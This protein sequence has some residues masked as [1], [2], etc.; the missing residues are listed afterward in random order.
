MLSISS[1]TFDKTGQVIC[2]EK[3]KPGR[4]GK[5]NLAENIYYLKAQYTTDEEAVQCA[6]ERLSCFVLITNLDQGY[7]S[8]HILKEYKAQINVE[9]S[10]KFLKDPLL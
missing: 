8:A 7:T 1:G 5:G 4:P 9:T 3:R 2:Q 6:K 10:F